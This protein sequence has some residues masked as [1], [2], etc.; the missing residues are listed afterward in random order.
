M[1]SLRWK[2]SQIE[3]IRRSVALI[4]PLSQ[5][6]RPEVEPV[7]LTP[8]EVDAPNP[9]GQSQIVQ[10]VHRL[11]D[12][13]EK[14]GGDLPLIAGFDED[15]SPDRGRGFLGPSGHHGLTAHF[16]ELLRTLEP[17]FTKGLVQFLSP[18]VAGMPA[19][20]R[21][22]CFVAALFHAAH[23][24]FPLEMLLR[25]RGDLLVEAEALA[26]HNEQKRRIDLLIRWTDHNRNAHCLAA[27][28]KFNAPVSLDAL[29]AYSAF[30]RQVAGAP[31]RAHLFLVTPKVRPLVVSEQGWQQ[32]T[33][34]SLLRHWERRIATLPIDEN[35]LLFRSALWQ[36]A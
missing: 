12:V 19:A 23:Q 15:I 28:V 29:D 27:E 34:L 13:A 8:A 16:P 4:A 3:G 20:E 35:F 18:A 33:W 30:A 9:P 1:R 10:A 32:V 22:R 36:R 11:R 14:L 21:T 6:L 2:A 7:M 5:M 26:P 31:E 17:N 25:P 24:S